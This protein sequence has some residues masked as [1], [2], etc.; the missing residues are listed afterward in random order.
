M[1]IK[2]EK[3]CRVLSTVFVTENTLNYFIYFTCWTNRWYFIWRRDLPALRNPLWASHPRLLGCRGPH[4]SSLGVFVTRAANGASVISP[5]AMQRLRSTPRVLA[6]TREWKR[7]HHPKTQISVWATGA[8]GCQLL[9]AWHEQKWALLP[10]LGIRLQWAY[11]K[12]LPF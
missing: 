7:K 12:Y 3:L 5:P 8:V 1:R 10:M 4:H 11:Y 6:R 9:A 2:W